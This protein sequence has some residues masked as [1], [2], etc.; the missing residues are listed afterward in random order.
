MV[1]EGDDPASSTASSDNSAEVLL[2]SSIAMNTSEI[3]RSTLP[4]AS[5][6]LLCRH[7]SE[8]YLIGV[9]AALVVCDFRV[10]L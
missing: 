7:R 10:A 6:G 5:L 8:Q 4:D 2:P 3:R 1:L 9:D